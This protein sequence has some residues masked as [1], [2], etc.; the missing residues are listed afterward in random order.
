MI[1]KLM[2]NGQNPIIVF[3]ASTTGVPSMYNRP[4]KAILVKQL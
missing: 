3:M 1:I 2:Q 4:I